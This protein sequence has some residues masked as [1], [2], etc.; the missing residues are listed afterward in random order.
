M[1]R[2]P[3]HKHHDAVERHMKGHHEGRAGVAPRTTD[4]GDNTSCGG[5]APDISKAAKSLY[6]PKSGGLKENH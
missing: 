1:G 5:G 6:S 4:D 3:A 2:K